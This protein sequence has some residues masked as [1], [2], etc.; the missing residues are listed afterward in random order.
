VSRTPRHSGK[1]AVRAFKRLGWEVDRQ[2]GDHVA[3]QRE[4]A[5]R[6]LVI[7]QQREL[8]DFIVS[9]LLNT[10]GV[11][12]NDYIYAL[13]KGRRKQKQKKTEKKTERGR[14]SG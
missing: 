1:E 9:N 12:R 6:P 11:E 14:G 7:P 8:P 13:K 3:M 2:R 10:A 4:G 5:V